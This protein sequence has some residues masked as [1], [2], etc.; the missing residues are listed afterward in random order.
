MIYNLS[1]TIY[2]FSFIIYIIF[3]NFINM[4][5][6]TIITKQPQ[7]FFCAFHITRV[8]QKLVR[9]YFLIKR[10]F[11]NLNKLMSPVILKADHILKMA[12]TGLFVIIPPFPPLL[13]SFLFPLSLS[14]S[15]FLFHLICAI[16]LT[17]LL[18]FLLS[19][20][21]PLFFSPYLHYPLLL[22]PQCISPFPI[23]P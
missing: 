20:F 23:A 10:T 18:Y 4:I 16:F 5:D 22:P 21:S 1:S 19:P 7:S 11:S 9:F 14:F 13:P 2:H 17:P 6:E 15:H 12:G 3:Y 8:I